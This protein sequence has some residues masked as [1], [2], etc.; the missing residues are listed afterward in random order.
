[1]VEDAIYQQVISDWNYQVFWLYGYSLQM[2]FRDSTCTTGPGICLTDKSSHF[3]RCEVQ[4]SDPV[5]LARTCYRRKRILGFLPTDKIEWAVIY[6][7]SY[8]STHISWNASPVSGRWHGPTIVRHEIAHAIGL[9]HD[10]DDAGSLLM[11]PILPPNEARPLDSVVRDAVY[12]KYGPPDTYTPPAAGQVGL[13]VLH[14]GREEVKEEKD[15]VTCP[16]F[17][18]G[19]CAYVPPP[20]C[21]MDSVVLEIQNEGGNGVYTWSADPTGCTILVQWVNTGVK[22]GRYRV[23]VTAWF[24]GQAVAGAP[25]WIQA[26]P[27]RACL[28]EKNVAVVQAGKTAS[29]EPVR[30][31]VMPG[32]VR[33][34]GMGHRGSGGMGPDLQGVIEVWDPGGRRVS[35][36]P[37]AREGTVIRLRRGVYVLR[38]TAGDRILW[39]RRVVIP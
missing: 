4:G 37:F 22:M 8:D 13:R 7:P 12:C 39:H 20:S 15:W 16:V 26:Y 14:P 19:G 30:L 17:Q 5:F 18:I 38:I 36:R 33:L 9:G 10:R 28:L 35:V 6:M 29:G 24:G 25:L 31:W 32:R 27:S 34:E 1:M 21:D 3:K 23:Q 11:K 2:D